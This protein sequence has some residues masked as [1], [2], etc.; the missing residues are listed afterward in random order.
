MTET[1]SPQAPA[2][3]RCMHCGWT[4]EAVPTDFN[5][6]REVHGGIMY[7]PCVNCRWYWLVT[8]KR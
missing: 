2:P 1:R 5:G 7:G 6:A 8:V 4:G 3:V